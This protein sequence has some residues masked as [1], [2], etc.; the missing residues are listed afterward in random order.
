R[1][2]AGDPDFAAECG[3]TLRR[4]LSR[5]CDPVKLAGDVASM[6]RRMAQQFP[7]DRL[8]DVK[9][10]AGGL[11]DIEFIVQYLMLRHAPARPDLLTPNTDAALLAFSRAGILADE[12]AGPL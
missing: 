6:R 5:P 12:T 3:M 11:V 2:I 1:V 8:W 10:L 4:I 9:H 7:T